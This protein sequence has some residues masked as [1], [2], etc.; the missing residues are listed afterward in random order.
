MTAAFAKVTATVESGGTVESGK[1][2]KQMDAAASCSQIG[3]MTHVCFMFLLGLLHL[4]ASMA[5]N[6]AVISISISTQITIR[7][8]NVPLSLS[9]R[10]LGLGKSNRR[11]S[12]MS[13]AC[14]IVGSI[15]CAYG[16]ALNA[17]PSSDSEFN[18][19]EIEHLLGFRITQAT[20]SWIMLFST[21]AAT[22][23]GNVREF[24]IH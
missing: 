19:A 22:L 11:D 15:L 18:A 2:A 20:G 4:L 14:L 1:H 17:A 3:T 8:I 10:L 6:I 9:L 16:L 7:S 24:L 13:D 23:A 21:L 12:R 5:K